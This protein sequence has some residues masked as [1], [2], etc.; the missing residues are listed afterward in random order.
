MAKLGFIY[1]IGGGEYEYYQF[2]EALGYRVRPYL[3]F[4][5]HA[6]GDENHDPDALKETGAVER[7]AVSARGLVPLDPDVVLW[8]CTSG[9]FIAGRAW[10]EDQVRGVHAVT[11]K[12]TSSTSIAF[13]NAVRHL[14]AKRVEL[15]AS[16]PERTSKAF[17]SFLGEHGIDVSHLRWMGA[18]G[19]RDAFLM[20]LERFMEAAREVDGPDVDAFLVPDTAIAGFPL[21]GPLEGELGKPVLTANQVT[22]WEA[23]RLAGWRE[24]IAGYGKLLAA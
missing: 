12:P 24:K 21:I 22:I 19:G 8:A 5:W 4:A 17:A 6:G 18:P 7:L 13:V 11:G 3:V 20:P 9:S 14:G 2:A 23:L 1:P 16:Y 15:L 10:A